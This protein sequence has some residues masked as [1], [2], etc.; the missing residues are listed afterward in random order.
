M[1][2]DNPEVVISRNKVSQTIIWLLYI[3]HI[4]CLYSP[5]TLSSLNLPL[6]SS[7]NTS[8]ELREQLTA[9][10]GHEVSVKVNKIAMYW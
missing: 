10:I 2:R 5:L 3:T 8:R 9:C 1:V 4:H 7:S 6:S